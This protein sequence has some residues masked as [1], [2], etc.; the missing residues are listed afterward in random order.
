MVK[1]L[2]FDKS[3]AD[4]Y[5]D[6]Y[7]N[8]HIQVDL[9]IQSVNYYITGKFGGGSLASLVNQ[10]CFT[11]L[12]LVVTINNPP[13][14]LFICQTFFHQMLYSPNI[15]ST[16]HL[17]SLNLPNILPTKLS[18]NTVY[19]LCISQLLTSPS[20]QNLQWLQGHLVGGINFLL[21]VKHSTF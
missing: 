20:L 6:I 14:D 3:W 1:D 21:S 19:N 4:S 8:T 18:C 5:T 12:K 16:K 17:K 11:K 2:I 9:K 15:L 13:A 7:S 10:V